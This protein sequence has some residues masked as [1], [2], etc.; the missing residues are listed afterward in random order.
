LV[1]GDV[2]GADTLH[3]RSACAA[4]GRRAVFQG[5]AMWMHSALLKPC[6]NVWAELQFCASSSQ[7]LAISTWVDLH[8]SAL[9]AICW[10]LPA[11]LL[12]RCAACRFFTVLDAFFVHATVRMCA[13]RLCMGAWVDVSFW[14]GFQS[15]R[16]GVVA[17]LLTHLKFR[18]SEDVELRRCTRGSQTSTL[19]PRRT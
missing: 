4:H 14:L 6:G 9:S 1:Q 18:I 7:A 13:N 2:C 3:H 11:F 16:A 8:T 19:P 17:L 12:R 10:Q 5:S 15:I